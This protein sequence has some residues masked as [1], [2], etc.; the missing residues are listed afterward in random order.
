MV[1]NH[2]N[3]GN[4]GN[5]GNYGYH[6]YLSTNH[7]NQLS[8]ISPILNLHMYKSI[9]ARIRTMVANHRIV[10]ILPTIEVPKLFPNTNRKYDNFA[11]K[12]FFGRLLLDSY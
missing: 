6:R 8:R 2:G 9:V 7:G 1:G 11:G 5:Y 3:H 10:R 4:H 12:T